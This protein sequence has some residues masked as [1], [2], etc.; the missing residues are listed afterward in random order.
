MHTT[1]LG[2]HGPEVSR[3]GLGTMALTATQTPAEAREMVVRAIDSGITLIDTA[4]VYGNGHVEEVLGAALK[5]RRESVVLATKVGLPMDGDPARAGGSKRWITTAIDDSLRRLQT[6]FVDLYQLHR[7]DPTTPI[8]ETVEAFDELIKAGK[9][10]YSGSSVFAAEAIVESQWSA[11]RLAAQAFVSEQAPYSI[12]VR[13]I[14]R[15]VLPTARRFGVGVLAWS[16]LNGGWLTGKYRRGAPVPEGSRAASGNPFVRAD[17]ERKLDL[18]DRLV[19][20][21]DQAGVSLLELSLAWTLVH[22]AISSVLLGPR[23]LEQLSD[24]LKTD[25]LIL[26]D[27]ILDAIDEIVAPGTDVDPRNSGSSPLGLTVEQ[28]R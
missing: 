13:G 16:P 6:D 21:A 8:D 3:F 7:P 25:G 22:P 11:E 18:V 12:F 19:S 5:G 17:D 27:D 9:I 14:E 2:A 1:T 4:D 24:M 26:S 23:T 20:V 28:R 15:S 10:R